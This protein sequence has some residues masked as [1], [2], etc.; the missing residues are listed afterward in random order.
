MALDFI[1]LE[2]IG[3]LGSKK[4]TYLIMG[5]ILIIGLLFMLVGYQMG[6]NMCKTYYEPL[7]ATARLFT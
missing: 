5:V 1:T 2:K 6:V 3:K 7:V 4:I